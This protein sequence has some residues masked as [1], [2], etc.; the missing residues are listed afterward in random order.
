[1]STL[2]QRPR[3]PPDERL[4]TLRA[5]S[6]ITTVG[7]VQCGPHVLSVERPRSGAYHSKRSAAVVGRLERVVRQ[8]NLSALWETRGLPR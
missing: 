5:R 2:K 8:V 7:C 3:F 4:A 1:M 6:G